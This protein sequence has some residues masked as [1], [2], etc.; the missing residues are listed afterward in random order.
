MS[1]TPRTDKQLLF[2][3]RPHALEGF[4]RMLERESSRFRAE[5]ALLKDRFAPAA[6]RI[7]ELKREV[8]ALKAE[9]ERL[10]A[11]H[12]HQYN[13]AGLMLREAER[14]QRA[15]S[16]PGGIQLFSANEVEIE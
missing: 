1:D 7:E 15:S 11:A 6:D 10:T 16:T 12:E 4:A 3:D 2:D 5:I 14:W 8:A 13:M 9:N